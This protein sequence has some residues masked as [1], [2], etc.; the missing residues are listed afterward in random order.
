MK[1]K[2]LPSPELDPETVAVI[3]TRTVMQKQS[4]SM[5]CGICLS[6]P[7]KTGTDGNPPMVMSHPGRVPS[8]QG[9][10]CTVC[11]MGEWLDFRAY[12]ILYL[13]P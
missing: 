1:S 5:P 12:E 8:Y 6:N 7:E 11:A 3:A 2:T 13:K 10:L 9:Y 4:S